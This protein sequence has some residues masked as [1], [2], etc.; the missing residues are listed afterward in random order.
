MRSLHHRFCFFILARRK[1][2]EIC[3]NQKTTAGNN[4]KG[5]VISNL[6]LY[7]L[8]LISGTIS[9]QNMFCHC[10]NNLTTLFTDWSPQWRDNKMEFPKWLLLTEQII[11]HNLLLIYRK[12]ILFMDATYATSH[13]SQYPCVTQFDFETVPFSISRTYWTT[14]SCQSYPVIYDAYQSQNSSSANKHCIKHQEHFSFQC[15]VT[16]TF[17]LC[18]IN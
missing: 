9:K 4:K 3:S 15:A 18:I 5:H 16:S 6:T 17:S 1:I 2:G 11:R 14:R 10:I 12:D 7:V 8:D 13:I